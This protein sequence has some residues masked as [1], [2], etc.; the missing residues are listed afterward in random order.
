M[1]IIFLTSRQM[2]FKDFPILKLCMFARYNHLS[3][4]LQ[5]LFALRDLAANRINFIEQGSFSSTVLLE[6]LYVENNDS[7]H[8]LKNKKQKK[9][10]LQYAIK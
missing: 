1:Q 5:V 7:G 8:E 10:L 3:C 4:I 9:K 2:I 6:T